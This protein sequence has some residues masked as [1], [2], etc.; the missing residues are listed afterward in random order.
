MEEYRAISMEAA[1]GEHIS[2]ATYRARQP[3]K[4]INHRHV[5]RY[6]QQWTKDPVCAGRHERVWTLPLICFSQ[7]E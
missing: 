6:S 5:T 1:A 4:A 7:I 2:Q 3:S